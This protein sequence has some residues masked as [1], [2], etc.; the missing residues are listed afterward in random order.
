MTGTV[1]VSSARAFE[2]FTDH[3]LFK[4]RQCA[5]DVDDPRRAAGNAALSRN[6]WIMED[7]DG[8]EPQRERE[9]REAACID[10]CVSCP[11]MVWCDAYATSVR[12][13][14]RMAE[15]RGIWGGRTALERKKLF[16]AREKPRRVVEAVLGERLET[17]QKRAV[18][19]A[20]AVCWDPF[21]VA[22]VASRLLI[23]CGEGRGMDVRTANWHRSNLTTL[24]GL[25][26]TV[27]RAQLLAVVGERGLLEGV[28][29]VAD[30][31]TVPAVPPP[32]RVPAVEGDGLVAVAGASLPLAVQVAVPAPE[33]APV[34]CGVER[35]SSSRRGRFTDVEGQLALWEAELADVHPLFLAPT[36]EP[37]GAAA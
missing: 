30:D 13:D 8:P 26:R 24:L 7:R 37:M 29:V 18:V 11:V 31:G 34:S 36:D 35:V 23:S 12:A 27:S 21:E 5:P 15:P 16:D 10:V 19:Q 22:A 32:T 4:Y 9:A 14:G 28:V 20:L 25:P 17:P 2:Q 3:P 33:L 6:A 1:Q